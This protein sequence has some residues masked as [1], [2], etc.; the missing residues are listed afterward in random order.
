MK[1][2]TVYYYFLKLVSLFL[3]AFPFILLWGLLSGRFAAESSKPLDAMFYVQ[4]A[5][6]G[7]LALGLGYLLWR[8][9]AVV[10][11]SDLGIKVSRNG[12][13][14]SASWADV[15]K[16]H[17][18]PFCT[19]PFYRLTF[20]DGRRPAYFCFFSFIVASVGFWS[21]DF[22]GFMSYARPR[23]E[24]AIRDPAGSAIAPSPKPL[25]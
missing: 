23:L 10:E 16:V 2:S 12:S 7:C 15:A 17:Q 13:D 20:R 14:E 21:W 18:I 24:S 25:F 3:F 8:N 5:L 19:P 1:S 6:S 4:M 11:F 22:R 9:F